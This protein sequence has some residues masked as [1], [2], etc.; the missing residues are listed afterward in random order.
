M[1]TEI[2]GRY[3]VENVIG[4]GAMAVVYKAIDP[5]IGRTVALK[6]MRFDVHGIEKNEV[7][8]RFRNEARAAGKLLHPN[9]VTIYDAGEQEGTFYIAME[10]VEGSTLQAVLSEQRFL[11]LDRTIDILSQI[12]SGLDYAHANGVVHRDIKPANI[13]LTRSGVVKIMDFGIAKAGAHLTTGGDVLGTPNYISPEMVKGD[14][15]DG[16]SDLFS[17]AVLLHEM[18]LGERPFTAPNISTII[19]KIV[20]EPPSPDLETKVHPAVAA[21][22]RKALSKHPSDRYQTGA[23]LVGAMKSYQALLTQPIPTM[24]V[25]GTPILT[26]WPAV[27]PAAVAAAPARVEPAPMRQGSEPSPAAY[28]AP[29]VFGSDV[30]LE[31]RTITAPAPEEKQPSILP[32]PTLDTRFPPPPANP[33][34]ST[35][36]PFPTPLPPVAPPPLRA[37]KK[38]DPG[39]AA[40]P[41][42]DILRVL[43]VAGMTLVVA[44][45][46][47]AGY[48]SLPDRHARGAVPVAAPLEPV[49]VAPPEPAKVNEETSKVDSTVDVAPDT[50]ATS[51]WSKKKTKGKPQT[52]P[53][54]ADPA[55]ANAP[56]VATADL[57]IAT[58]PDGAT[59][60]L[61]GQSRN[62][63]TP[64]TAAA[65]SPGSH[66]LIF[67]KPG[68]QP[69]ARS[70]DITAGNNAS[71]SVNLSVAPTAVVCESNPAGAAIF[72]DEEPTGLV[73]P[74]TVKLSPGTHEIA[75]DKQG[76]DEG[77]GSV[78]LNQGETQ[79]FSVVLQ[80]GD[81]QLRIRRVF[82]GAKDK[83]MIVIRSRPRGATI[84]LDDT[85]VDAATPA[86]II[87]RNGKTR[88]TVEKDGYKPYH[89]D[90]QVDKGEIVVVDA[91]LEPKTP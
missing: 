68:Y 43:K 42:A 81:R 72:I 27:A 21:I 4:R 74:A 51:M 29:E 12:C 15:V 3:E 82:A 23:D 38:M 69:V 44:V 19:Y 30:P 88:L 65:L 61:D 41:I 60:Q 91:V 2:I 14:A 87:V 48:N 80:P 28:Q 1:P 63:K 70:V 57:E 26:N 11:N 83:G 64:F 5:T 33:V 16:R 71:I 56:A 58:A 76:Y 78:Q 79:H 85:N 17:V 32:P 89:R 35:F 47:I 84:R 18:L 53:S 40:F 67:T 45:V 73:T 55:P 52:L 9:L 77:T 20:N 49:V 62:E 46:C 75:V 34:S 25:P 13:M 31:F 10:C 90:V 59:V 6:T 24:V 86:R 37:A 7:L 36:G 22:M 66:T 50:S 8:L 39:F 54:L